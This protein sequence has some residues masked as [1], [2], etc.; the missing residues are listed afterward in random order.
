MAFSILTKTDFSLFNVYYG[1]AARFCNFK[2]SSTCIKLHVQP[3]FQDYEYHIITTKVY[4]GCTHVLVQFVY[5]LLVFSLNY[6]R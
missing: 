3:P 4:F 1:F 2:R 6:F 5:L